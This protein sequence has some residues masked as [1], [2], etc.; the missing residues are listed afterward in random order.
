[1]E[2]TRFDD[3]EY[4]LLFKMNERVEITNGEHSQPQQKQ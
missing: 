4:K 3:H 1:M 2:L